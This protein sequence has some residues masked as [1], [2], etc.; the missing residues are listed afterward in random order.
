MPAGISTLLTFLPKLKYLLISYWNDMWRVPTWTKPRC[1]CRTMNDRTHLKLTGDASHT[2]FVPALN[3][4]YH[5]YHG[6]YAEAVHVFI[7][8]G[9]RSAFYSFEKINEF[10]VGFGTGLNATLA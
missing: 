9:L 7:E 6:D 8:T 1:S 10:E 5:S 2:L 3:E 4:N